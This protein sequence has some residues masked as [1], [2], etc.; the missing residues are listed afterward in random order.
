MLSIISEENIAFLTECMQRPEVY[1]PVGA[2]V[3]FVL[4]FLL[5]GIGFFRF[6]LS[7]YER[8]IIIAGLCALGVWLFFIGREHQIYLDNK[9]FGEFVALE[10]VNVSING[11]E[12]AELMARDRDVRKAVG[13]SFTL[14]AEVFDE[15]GEIVNTLTRTIE[16]KCSKDIMIN[17]P[18]LVGGSEGFILPSPR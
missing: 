9:A 12:A 7:W 11:G 14:K 5:R 1:I 10:Q 18:A 16:P 4:L 13:L 8:L 3:L 6:L 15:K 2:V 17:L